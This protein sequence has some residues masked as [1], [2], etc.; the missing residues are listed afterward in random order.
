MLKE[1][2]KSLIIVILLLNCM[3]LTY[4]LWFGS[5]I[6]NSEGDAPALSDLPFVRAFT[7]RNHVSVPKENLSKP[8]KLV[9]NDGSLWVPYYNTDS[10]FGTLDAQT[11]EIIKACL[12]GE[13][14]SEEI[15]YEQWLNYLTDPSVYIE[16]PITVSPSL[17]AMILG[18]K[19]EKFP[20][21]IENVKDAIIIPS[22]SESV[23]VAVCDAGR[24]RAYVFSIED[25][26]YAFPEEVL[27]MFADRNRR[28]GYYEFAFSTLIGSSGLGES[29]VTVDDLVLFSDNFSKTY[30]ISASNPLQ[31]GDYSPL[32]KSFSFNA[33]PLRHYRAGDGSENYVENYA[34][35][36]IY[37]DGY[38]EYSAVNDDKG[39]FLTES[40]TSE[41]ELLNSAID[42]AEDVWQSVSE[43]PLNVLVSGVEKN[44]AETK[45]VFDY[46][47]L[48]REVAVST[49]AV[50]REPLYHAI[51][52]TASEGR[53]TSYRQYLRLYE[54]ASLGREQESFV[55]ALDY[56]VALFSEHGDV[57]ITDLYP[58]YYDNGASTLLETTWLSKVNYSEER[59]PKR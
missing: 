9:V 36:R 12:R 7:Q 2:V 38:I 43:E 18:E 3:F 44:G 41:Y 14:E 19:A 52:M 46:Y 24:E 15:T 50:G 34:T 28:D 40:G 59:I 20:P 5:G 29:S 11:G 47:Y 57:K 51:E 49:S 13:G 53:I 55:T 42:F 56:F 4:K 33:Q 58:G 27:A 45:F 8:R 39:V 31:R 6:L 35:V 54:G 21:G 23:R 37:P 25:E 26:R 17:L 1:R 32:L 22:G 10:A 16:Y 48:G 30:C